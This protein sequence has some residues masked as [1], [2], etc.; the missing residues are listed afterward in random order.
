M[1][2]SIFVLNHSIMHEKRLVIPMEKL[3]RN[4]LGLLIP[5]FLGNMFLVW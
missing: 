2:L 3:L 5:K 1:Q 4:L